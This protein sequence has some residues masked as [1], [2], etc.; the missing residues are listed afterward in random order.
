MDYKIF[1]SGSMVEDKIFHLMSVGGQTISIKYMVLEERGRT[2]KY[3]TW[4][5]IKGGKQD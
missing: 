4:C 2:I 3:S 5:Q 1:H